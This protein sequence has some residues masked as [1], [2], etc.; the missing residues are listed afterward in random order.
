M[1]SI[2]IPNYNK[3]KFLEDTFN[4]LL[5]QTSDDWEAVI[6]DDGSTDHS[7]DICQNYILKDHRFRYYLRDRLPK[8]ANTCRNIGIEKSKGE[9][10]IFLDSD[11][12]MAPHCI[13]QRS[14]FMEQS[15]IDFAVFPTGT[16]KERI[17]D[18]KKFWRSKS[19][20]NHL[21]Q[22]L[23]HDLPWNISSP[24]WRKNFLIQ[25]HCFN[26]HY[27]RLQ[28]VEFH[29][30]ILLKASANYAIAENTKP[31]CFYRIGTQRI[32][33]DYSMLVEK[34]VQ[35]VCMYIVDMW[36][37]I[38]ERAKNQGSLRQ[39]LKGTIFK[40][41]RQILYDAREGKISKKEKERFIGQLMVN[42]T[43]QELLGKRGAGILKIYRKGFEM[44]I[45]KLK[46]YNFFMNSLLTK[47]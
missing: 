4:S 40:A 36:M 45:G 12:K 16:F 42:K 14:I 5:L 25:T 20:K 19:S 41:M 44:G 38:N 37:L 21:V 9:Y 34:F 30:R 23:R 39:A 1:V 13:E 6:V 15:S 43:V 10:I 47:T 17:G 28:D 33:D 26:E 11:D 8:G 3:A 29:T 24:I 2:I 22:F 18:S 35:G 31:D 46:G 27:P 7:S 32:V